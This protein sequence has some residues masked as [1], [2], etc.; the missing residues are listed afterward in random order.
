MDIKSLSIRQ[1]WG[2][3]RMSLT[4]RRSFILLTLALRVQQISIA[5]CSTTN[6]KLLIMKYLTIFAL[7]LMTAACTDRVC[8]E[9]PDEYC[10]SFDVRQCQTDLFA[11]AVVEDGSQ[12]DR[13]SQM[14]AWLGEQDLNINDVQLKV[15]YLEGVCE[16]CD[17]CPMG[18]RYF[19]RTYEP[20]LD[21]Q[22]NSLQLLNFEKIDCDN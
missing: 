1:C 17:V 16:A 21:V 22:V 15:Q 11:E 9:L 5:M 7:L 2:S 8:C 3:C 4:L 14:R 6:T 12:A 10:Y 18:D 20:N 19:L 13:E